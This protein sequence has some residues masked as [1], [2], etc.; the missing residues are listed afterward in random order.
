MG[1]GKTA[2]KPRQYCLIRAKWLVNQWLYGQELER[3]MPNTEQAVE[4]HWTVTNLGD[5]ILAA[6]QKMGKDIDALTPADLAPID[7]FHI[8]GRES[9]QELAAH[10]GVRPE[11]DVLDVGSG[12]GGSARYLA[13]EYGCRVT[14]LDLTQAYCDVATMLSQR[15]GLSSRTVFHHGSALAMPFADA[16]FDLAWTEHA[17]MNIADKARFYGEI[18]RVLKPGGRLAF[19]DIFQ[20]PGGAV[21]FPVPWAGEPSISHFITPDALGALLESVGFQVHHWH[22]VSQEALAWFQR[23][24]E[25]VTLHGPPLLGTHL[26]LGA[27]ARVTQEHQLRNLAEGRI[28]ALQVVL[29]KMH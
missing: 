1:M 27:N 19:H 3:C 20:G 17:Q 25:H 18:A 8:R 7:E 12:L 9:T 11:W 21:Y 26:L 29:E 13:V 6:L 14:G 2:R 15:L 16:T 22:D 24:V 5:T 4:T 10:A 28:V 23:A